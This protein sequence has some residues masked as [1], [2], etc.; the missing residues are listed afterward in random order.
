MQFI[1]D[2]AATIDEANFKDPKTLKKILHPY[3]P[4]KK[5]SC[6]TVQGT[7]EEVE[8]LFKKLQ[9]EHTS[10]HVKS[11]DVSAAVMAYI[12][13]KCQ[14]ELSKIRGNSFDIETQPDLRTVQNNPKGT[15]QVTLRPC[16]PSISLDRAN[17]VRQRFITFYQ[18]TASDLQVKTIPVSP[19]QKDDL[20]KRFPHLLFQAKQNNI[21]VT[22]PFM[23][24]SLLM[25]HHLQH[26]SSSKKSP[27][28]KGP[29]DSRSS[30]TSGPSPRHSKDCEDELCPICMDSIERAKKVSLPCKHSFCRD[31]LKTAF[32]YKPVCP[33]CGELYGTLTG[34]QPDGGRMIVNTTSS[35]LP[36][37][38]KY[39]TIIIEY[40][41]PSGIQKVRLHNT[42]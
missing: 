34:T 22:G 32:D 13:K 1:T 21:E 25:E 28:H 2:I 4:K 11:V 8:D 29:A 20:Q 6:Y 37:Y 35:C 33:T 19:H 17:M 16:H 15:V 42:E 18:R 40:H 27:V 5:D 24:I 38:E 26:T 31:C 41:I 10:T 36:G 9:G 14:N 3:N 23:H 30:R 39:R 7:Y 12:E